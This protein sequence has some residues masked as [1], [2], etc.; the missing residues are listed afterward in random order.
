MKDGQKLT[1]TDNV[2]VI[3]SIKESQG[4]EYQCWGW[5]SDGT[6]FTSSVKVIVG[7]GEFM[8][9][10]HIYLHHHASPPMHTITFVSISSII[11][12]NLYFHFLKIL[13]D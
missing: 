4:G 10:L 6:M 2:Y 3:N 7:G 9:C 13:L 8:L 5:R 12:F 11:C 1:T